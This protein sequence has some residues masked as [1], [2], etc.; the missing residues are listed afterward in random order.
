MRALN[1]RFRGIDKETDV[2][3]FPGERKPLKPGLPFALGDIVIN[4]SRA[5]RQS[6]E[7]GLSFKEELRW[8]LVHGLLHLIGYDHE[9]SRYA[10][11]KMRRKERQL[12][13]KLSDGA[14]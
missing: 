5:L 9:R 7:H 10:G 8:L 11:Q 2:L 1:L 13:E 6:K 14:I 4:P 12:L 3:S